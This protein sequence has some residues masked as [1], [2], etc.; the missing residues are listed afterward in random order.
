[1]KFKRFYFILDI[2]KILFQNSQNAVAEG[3]K[4][5][6]I[7]FQFPFQSLRLLSIQIDDQSSNRN[8]LFFTNERSHC[9]R[10]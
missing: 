7:R 2:I 3:T 5:K 1:M 6:K 10:I 8:N 9:Q 4:F